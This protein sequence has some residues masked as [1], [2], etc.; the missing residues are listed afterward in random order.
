MNSLKQTETQ[1]P[2]QGGSTDSV[3]PSQLL[4][5]TLQLV[6]VGIVI[7]RWGLEAH[8]GLP[9][10]FPVVVATFLAHAS[11]PR[12]WRPGAYF[13]CSIGTILYL[14][15]LRDG[16][17]VAVCGLII[18][19]TCHLP[20]PQFVKIGLLA[21]QA[22]LLAFFNFTAS[23]GHPLPLQPSSQAI[24]GL[25][26]LFMF[27]MILYLYELP[28]ERDSVSTWQRLNYF[29]LLPNIC[30]P[31]FPVLDY[32]VFKR[33]YYSRPEYE[34]YKRG[35][36]LVSLGTAQLVLYRCL[37]QVLPAASGVSDAVDLL[38]YASISYLMLIRFSGILQLS[39][40]LL[41]LFGLYLPDIF[42]FMFFADSYADLWR[43]V[44]IYWK[45]FV[46]KIV[47][48]PWYFRLKRRGTVLAVTVATFL[49]FVANWFFHSYQWFWALGTFPIRATEIV[50]WG[51]LGAMVLV[52]N[53]RQRK[54]AKN[55]RVDSAT[56][57]GIR[58]LRIIL[59][60]LSMSL[61]YS[62]FVS[63]SVTEWLKLVKTA[64]RGSTIADFCLILL[65]IAILLVLG[66]GL[67]TFSQSS[68]RPELSVSILMFVALLFFVALTTGPF[69]RVARSQ[70]LNLKPLIK[71][72]LNRQDAQRQSL[73]YYEDLMLAGRFGS[74]LWQLE[75]TKPDGWGRELEI[76][77]RESHFLVTLQP[78]ASTVFK[79]AT[80]TTNK[81]GL[82]DQDYDLEKPD[83]VFRFALVG[84]SAELGVG[85]E[86]EQ[87]FE[88]ILEEGLN[89][90]AGDP[91]I[92]ILNFSLSG[93]KCFRTLEM[94]RQKVLNFEP[95]HIL[96]FAHD[97]EEIHAFQALHWYQGDPI[98]AENLEQSR[99][100]I[101][102]F[103]SFESLVES[104]N[105]K[106]VGSNERD[107]VGWLLIDWTYEQLHDMTGPRGIPVTL[108]YL[109]EV[110]KSRRK[111]A[112]KFK[113]LS[114]KHGFGFIDLSEAF[115]QREA[116]ELRL[117]DWDW[118][119]N[120]KAHQLIAEALKPEVTKLVEGLGGNRS[121][122]ADR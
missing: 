33:C 97:R 36:Y 103:S 91:R 30:F 95:D 28:H 88:H 110:R 66:Q 37:Y 60:F 98:L 44:N 116:E 78:S 69:L 35:V 113:E 12:T 65:V 105:L 83:G 20:V 100:E 17:T 118:H 107:Q 38:W 117:R 26:A 67:R 19:A 51:I 3:K 77:R 74:T 84:G 32:K 54:G 73:G 81:W 93:Q 47:Y 6:I 29:F 108:I 68:V 89:K 8:L 55:S 63:D 94:I 24:S 1:G 59:T 9:R 40:G 15:G 7:S 96:L 80:I 62:L 2:G 21:A 11:L 27:R 86:R 50:V 46:V 41:C 87:V 5:L 79:E 58:N 48:Y 115:G 75:R 43:R 22:S 72:R 112:R 76:M 14:L 70:G 101:P 120:V 71:N 119:P 111:S 42:K 52:S 31:I 102:W 57:M 90:E 18:F 61:V 13:F 106:E 10:L 99:R 109:P 16:A 39:V 34:I 56:Q 92:E 45:D 64:L 23:S 53:L 121:G 114:E 104:E 85:V 25:G 4:L 82:R 49:T 122:H